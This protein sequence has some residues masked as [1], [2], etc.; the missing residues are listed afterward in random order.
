M[1][2]VTR[3]S[4][5]AIVIEERRGKKKGYRIPTIRECASLQSF[6]ITHQF[7]ASSVSDKYKLVGNAVPP[8]LSR[9]IARSI[10]IAM[11]KSFP[12]EPIIQKSI[13]GLPKT[14]PLEATSRQGRKYPLNKHFR[15]FIGHRTNYSR[16]GCRIDIDNRGDRPRKH[17]MYGDT[18]KEIQHLTEWRCVLYMGYAKDVK[19]RVITLREAMSLINKNTV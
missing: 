16:T 15:D 11:R 7:W 14:L 10:L 12:D 3:N 18:Q 13:H 4:R 5:E 6:P 8:I 2:S 9:A 17:P 1:A 19:H